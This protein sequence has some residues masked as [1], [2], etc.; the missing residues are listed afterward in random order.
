MK[1]LNI[2]FGLGFVIAVYLGISY[3]S[4]YVDNRFRGSS[5]STTTI[6]YFILYG[7]GFGGLLLFLLFFA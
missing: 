1:L 2:I 4:Y 6:Y 3:L 7:V 5:Y